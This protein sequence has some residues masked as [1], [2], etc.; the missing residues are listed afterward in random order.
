MAAFYKF[1]LK[2]IKTIIAKWVFKPISET[3][4]SN[5]VYVYF[6]KEVFLLSL[7]FLYLFSDKKKSK[8]YIVKK[9]TLN[10]Q[11]L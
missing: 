2:K 3:V 8:T 6:Y 9:Q 4:N 7:S 1:A 5:A 10:V 11:N